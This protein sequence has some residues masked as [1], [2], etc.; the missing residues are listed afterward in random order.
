MNAQTQE[1]T[2][3]DK[4]VNTF[5]AFRFGLNFWPDGKL[6]YNL[7]EEY[8]M[9]TV[10]MRQTNSM[11]IIAWKHVLWCGLCKDIFKRMTHAVLINSQNS[12]FKYG[13]LNQQVLLTDIG[14]AKLI[15]RKLI[16]S[17]DI[18][19]KSTRPLNH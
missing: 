16:F 5:E 8:M 19:K 15:T 2:Y 12:E 4:G 7:H 3:R 10:W 11:R 18:R 9:E 13:T 6:L 1:V 17:I 14:K